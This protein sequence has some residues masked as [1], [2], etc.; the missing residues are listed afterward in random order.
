MDRFN[1]KLYIHTYTYKQSSERRSTRARTSR[2][3]VT[4]SNALVNSIIRTG[5]LVSAQRSF[6]LCENHAT[7]NYFLETKKSARTQYYHK[8]YT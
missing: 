1:K 3:P 6:L 5:K 8:T 4:Q 7:A 2:T